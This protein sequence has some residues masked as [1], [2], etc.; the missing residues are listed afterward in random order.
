[1]YFYQ[2]FTY[3]FVKDIW[4]VKRQTVNTVYNRGYGIFYQEELATKY[5]S[6]L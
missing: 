5:V 2:T 6:F 4:T 3:F 1:M